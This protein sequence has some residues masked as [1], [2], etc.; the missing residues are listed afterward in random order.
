[1]HVGAWLVRAVD[2]HHDHVADNDSREVIVCMW[3]DIEAARHEQVG[4]ESKRQVEMS[5]G[6]TSVCEGKGG[7][8]DG[9]QV[10]VGIVKE[11]FCRELNGS[12]DGA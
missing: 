10:V 3:Q 7:M 8:V 12:S 9:F 4:R 5:S 11:Q 2:Q 1:M 6:A